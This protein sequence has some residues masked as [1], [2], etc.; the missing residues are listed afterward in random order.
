MMTLHHRH[1]PLSLTLAALLSSCAS[2][3]DNQAANGSMK[4]ERVDS[5]DAKIESVQVRAVESGLKISGRLRKKYHGRG[6]IPGH[7]HIKVIDRNGEMLAQTTS[8]Y[9]C[10]AA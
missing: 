8:G 4:V 3:P 5:R 9:L 2:L 1:R 10:A 6:A 7:L